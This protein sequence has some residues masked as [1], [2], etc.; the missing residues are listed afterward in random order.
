MVFGN[1]LYATYHIRFQDQIACGYGVLVPQR[2]FYI[3][4]V[5]YS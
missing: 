5:H 1:T 3:S 2:D 4:G